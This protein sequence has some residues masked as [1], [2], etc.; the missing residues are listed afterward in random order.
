MLHGDFELAWQWSDLA[1]HC[2]RR[3]EDLAGKRVLLRCEHGLGDSIQFIRYARLLRSIVSRILVH[4]Q[5]RLL[6]L[7]RRLPEIDFAF[8]WGNPWPLGCYDCEIEIMDL[9]YLFRSTLDT[10]PRQVPYLY[11]DLCAVVRHRG[12]VG[13][14]WSAGDWDTRRS[15]PRS[16]LAP[17]YKVRGLE[18]V[19]LQDGPTTPDVGAT[20]AEI[21]GLDLV[22]TVDTMVAHLAGALAKPAWVLLPHESDWRWMQDRDDSPWYPT[23]RL[24]RQGADLEWQPVVERVAAELRTRR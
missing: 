8:T 11:L 3:L 21:M 19:S 15:V 16:V 12:A 24:F 5:P 20:A 14:Q 2:T 17:L 1:P 23:M 22:I 6:P 9:P 4:V 7:I 18:I 13:L 10:L